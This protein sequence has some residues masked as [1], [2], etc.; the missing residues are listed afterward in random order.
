MDELGVWLAE[1]FDGSESVWLSTWTF[2]P[3]PWAAVPGRQYAG[4][5]LQ[6]LARWLDGPDSSAFI[7]MERGEDYSQRLHLHSIADSLDAIVNAELRWKNRYGSSNR[8][9]RCDSKSGVA[10]YVSKYVTK[11]T[12]ALVAPPFEACGPRFPVMNA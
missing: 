5:A 11:R 8:S 2:A 1:K 10:M 3:T 9:E 4:K 7:S 12:G 6:N